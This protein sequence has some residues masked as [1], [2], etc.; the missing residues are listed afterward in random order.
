M[1]NGKR[2]QNRRFLRGL[3]HDFR[4]SP[5]KCLILCLTLIVPLI[6]NLALAEPI[7]ID[8]DAI[9][10]IESSNNPLA[11]NEKSGA[12]G[13]FQIREIALKDYNN[14]HRNRMYMEADLFEGSVSKE[15][16]IWLFEVR[17]PQLLKHYELE[18]NLKN[19]LFSYNWG[20]KNVSDWYKNGAKI[21]YVPT[22]TRNYYDR[23]IRYAN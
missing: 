23:Y 9:A 7:H 12:R 1:K 6:A 19:L 2:H 3:R 16:A 18:V 20:T 10:M 15:I 13:L 22:E 5:L 11:Y 17:I 14:Y 4:L 8:Y 21:E